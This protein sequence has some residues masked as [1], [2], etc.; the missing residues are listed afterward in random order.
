MDGTNGTLMSAGE[1]LAGMEAALDRL[2][3]DRSVL[4]PQARLG[5]VRA[6]RR[7]QGRVA[8]LAAVLTAE[9]DSAK[10]AETTAGTP[11]SS[12]LGMGEPLSRREAAG[13]VRQARRLGQ[14]RLL[15]EAAVAGTVG[16]GQARAITGVLDGLADQ[17]DESQQ[18]QAE[19]VLVE[20][21]G[22]LDADQLSK[23]AGRVLQVVAAG[24]SE[25]TLEQHLQREAERAHRERRLR[26]FYEGASVRFDGSLPRLV[27][28]KWIAQLD[29]RQEQTRRTVIERRDRLA[30][31]PTPEQR[32]ADALIALIEQPERMAAGAGEPPARVMVMVDYD[33]LAAD[34]AAA[35]VLPDGQPLSA[36]ELRRTCCDA[37]I[38]PVV[39]GA[40]SQVLDVGRAER[41]V[42]PEL[43]TALVAR[44]RGCVFPGCDAPHTRCEA[45]HVIP[46]WAGGDTALHNLVLL[47]HSHHPVVEPAR[48][49]VRDQWQVRIAAD[50]IPEFSPPARIDPQQKPV[51]HARH[52][53]RGEN[54]EADPPGESG[55]I[56]PPH[57]A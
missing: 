19:Q 55:D 42:T 1:V 40:V 3:P 53:R 50:G 52:Q 34:A 21:A 43:R 2:D 20:L 29:A 5:L 26:F 47:C 25:E 30:E 44:D 38:V 39:L 48:F 18:A 12:W 54:S 32:R 6:A 45:H 16:P 33:K 37:E 9:A 10:A 8:A 17:L 41:L 31:L 4:D 23:A 22:Q 28:E 13:Q 24:R 36:G 15:G 14:H 51:R 57:A 11:L 35:G 56:G 46:W 49:A 7:V 27:A